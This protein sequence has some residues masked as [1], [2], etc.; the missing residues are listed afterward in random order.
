MRTLAVGDI[1]GCSAALDALLAIVRP[2]PDDRLVFLGDYVDRG[3]DTRGVLDR[4]LALRQSHPNTIFLR[5]NHEIMMH[6]ARIDR[7][8]R[9]DWLSVGGDRAL[10]SYSADRT[11]VGFNDVPEE[12]WEFVAN[13]LRDWYE[14]PSHIFV[15]ANLDP[16]LP[17]DE[18]PEV[19]LF[20]EFLAEPIDHVSGKT[21]I[22]GHTTQRGGK[23]VHHGTTIAIDTG[24]FKP[25]GW[26]TCVDVDMDLYWQANQLGETRMGNLGFRGRS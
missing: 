9:T 16:E 20:W 15:H 25:E 21:V 1:H 17:L 3:P 11:P 8:M 19:M 4:L 2:T 12:H 13:G 18:Q 6:A 24:A 5:G 22:V 14:T 7:G 26:L 10:M 23:P